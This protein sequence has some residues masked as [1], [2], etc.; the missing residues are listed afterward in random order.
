MEALVADVVATG[1]GAAHLG[2]VEEVADDAGDA[3][4]DVQFKLDGLGGLGG[5]DGL[6]GAG[7]GS[8]FVT[9]PPIG[10][11]DRSGD[12][13]SDSEVPFKLISKKILTSVLSSLHHLLVSKTDHLHQ[14]VCPVR[15][16]HLL[17]Q[18][19]NVLADV[20]PTFV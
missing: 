1:A 6:D 17:L 8:P 19:Q 12:D 13:G 16:H 7:L 15:G 5:L 18:Q 3:E 9:T 14:P 2:E 10:K 4:E 20:I 11:L